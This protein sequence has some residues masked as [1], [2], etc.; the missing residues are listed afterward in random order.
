MN[1]GH[2][3]LPANIIRFEEPN[4]YGA[5]YCWVHWHLEVQVADLQ[6]CQEIAVC[7]WDDSINCQPEL[8]SWNLMGMMNNNWFRIKVHDLPTGDGIWFEHPTRVEPNLSHYWDKE[9]GLG[10][11]DRLYLEKD[12]SLPSPGW[13]DRLR[14]MV[15]KAHAPLP[16]E[17][18]PA[19]GLEYAQLCLDIKAGVVL[20]KTRGNI[21]SMAITPKAMSGEKNDGQSVGKLPV[22]VGK[23]V[24]STKEWM[25]DGL[26]FEEV[27]K[28]N[29]EGSVWIVVKGGVYDCTPYLNDHPGG[30]SSI[31][32]VGGMESTDEFEAVHSPK[33]WKMLED[34]FIGPL[35]QGSDAVPKPLQSISHDPDGSFL[36][37]RVFQKLPLVEKIVVSH[38]T[39]IFRFGL[40]FP[41]MTLGLP[42]GQHMFLKSQWKGK[43]VMR[44]YTPMT[45]DYTKGHVDLLVKVYF[46]NVHPRFPEGG[47]M[48]QALDSMKIGD[49]I[50]VKG[51]L[52]E[53]NYKGHGSFTW[54]DKPRKC[55][56]ISMIAGGTGLTPCWQVANGILRDPTDETKVSLL[57]ANQT[58]GDI[59]AR[60]Q[61]EQLANNN[62]ER[63]KLWY[64]VDR[65]PQELQAAEKWTYDIGFVNETLIKNHLF[66]SG[67][68]RIAVMCGPPMMQDKACTPNLLKL[69]YQESDIFAF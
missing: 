27:A 31:L 40:P 12:G 14:D 34:Y 15:V 68:G 49:C 67:E 43:T 62:P 35:R 6:Q 54:H 18:Q 2:T 17:E 48:S 61:L 26:S 22:T 24:K 52:G 19:D 3:W 59:L 39:R 7:C 37:P 23:F 51:P 55:T 69:G 58:P 29:S 11:K 28:H 1:D 25:E 42:T 4:K 38:D 53:F 57:Y 36:N 65:V 30:A 45:D 64:T 9:F 32:L 50:E 21:D 60:A 47:Q 66:E 10:Q 46:A 41:T 56:H 63:F 16:L 8:P 20:E 44:P 33:A 5:E 13:M